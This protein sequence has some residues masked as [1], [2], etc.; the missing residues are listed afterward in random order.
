MKKVLTAL[1][2][3][4]TL[5]LV[6]PASA[7]VLITDES[8][9]VGAILHINPDDDPIA[10][11][12]STVYFDTQGELIAQQNTQLS[13]TVTGPTNSTANPKT[14]IDGTLATTNYTFPVQGVYKLTYIVNT[15]S[16]TTV[17]NYTQRVSRGKAASALD[18]PTH[19]W[20]E[21]AVTFASAGLVVLTVIAITQ[22]K[23]ILQRSKSK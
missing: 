9:T 14:A 13:L 11:Q 23:A 7:H 2:I 12:E 3:V 16:K 18:T 22:R 1:I 5:F 6:T 8:Q 17:F 20:A 21:A 4:T 10:G 19:V 15:N